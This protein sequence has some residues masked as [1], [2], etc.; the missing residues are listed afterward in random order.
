MGASNSSAGNAP[1][2]DALQLLIN[3]SDT[4]PAIQA[5]FLAAT[6][7]IGVVLIGTALMNMVEMSA[8]TS[9]AGNQ[10]PRV[11]GVLSQLIIGGVLCSSAVWMYI[12]GNTFVGQSVNTSAMLYGGN[13]STNCDKAEYAIFF[14]FA[15]VGQIA[16]AKGWYTLNRYFNQSAP[17]GFWM[18]CWFIVGGVACYFLTDVGEIMAEWFG[19]TLSTAAFC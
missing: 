16:F 12:A 6:T 15:L 2:I 4:F 18:G 8:A 3:A 11:K 5:L 10:T 9:W 19:L 13:A 17:D 7:L 14:F 1:F